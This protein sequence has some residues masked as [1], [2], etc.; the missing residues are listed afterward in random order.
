[1]ADLTLVKPEVPTALRRLSDDFLAH[2]RAKGLSPKTWRDAYRY[3][4]EEVFLPWCAEQGITEPAQLSTRVVERFT[5]H[6]LEDGGRRGPLSKAS[7]GSY[8]RSV[9]AFLGWAEKEGELAERVKVPALK[10][11]RRVLD[12]LS[13]DE[14]QAMEDV[15]KSERDKLLVRVLADT[16]LRLGELLGLRAADIIPSG[17]GRTQL[18]VRGKGDQERLVPLSPALARRL[19]RH[20]RGLKAEGSDR[21]FVALRKGPDGRYAPLTQSGAE[22]AIRTLAVSAG[23]ERR[24]YPHLLRHSFATHALRRGMSTIQLQAILGHSS[25]T[26]IAQ[27]YSHLTVDDAYDAMMALLR[28]ED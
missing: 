14:I 24:V 2:C 15:A 23:I 17:S 22:Q 19:A 21:I 7:V 13:R 10:Q 9:R 16:G 4:L 8:S 6:L 1:M 18:K 27:V 11:T 5:T 26:M 3:A 25:L 12:V 28:Q 20:L